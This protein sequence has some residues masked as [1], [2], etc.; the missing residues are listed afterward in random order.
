[1]STNFDVQLVVG[2]SESESLRLEVMG[3][4]VNVWGGMEGGCG[5]GGRCCGI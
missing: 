2:A 3:A 1:M 4:F 5:I